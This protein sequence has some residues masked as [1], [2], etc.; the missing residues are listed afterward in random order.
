MSDVIHQ[1]RTLQAQD[2][3]PVQVLDL[4]YS[5]YVEEESGD[6]PLKRS[7][8]TINSSFDAISAC[9]PPQTPEGL[10]MI[11]VR[12]GALSL[13]RGIERNKRLLHEEVETARQKK[14]DL[15]KNSARSIREWGWLFGAWKSILLGG[16]AY[17][18]VNAI[19]MLPFMNDNMRGVHQQYAALATALAIAI[20]SSVWRS[21]STTWT[22]NAVVKQ[23]EESL[24]AANEK[25]ARNEEK[26]YNRALTIAER[27]WEQLTGRQLP[28]HESIMGHRMRHAIEHHE[29]PAEAT[30]T[31][32]KTSS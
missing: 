2:V 11:R 25:Y 26:E 15:I 3:S 21:W 7:A 32:H 1:E 27:G 5:L 8:K 16:F 30:P 19:I 12:M 13:A 17:A 4:G 23:Y 29:P 22:I 24:I 10:Y 31:N 20:A 14:N 9:F 28:L 6:G 18:M